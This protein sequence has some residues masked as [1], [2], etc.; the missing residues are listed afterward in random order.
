MDVSQM[1]RA[2][3]RALV[4]QFRPKMILLS[5]LPLLISLLL[6]GALMAWTLQ[7]VFDLIQSYLTEHQYFNNA[8]DVLATL[9]LMGFKAVIVPLF[10][11]WLLL[12]IMIMSS[13]LFVG[14][15]AMPVIAKHVGERDFPHIV[16]AADG[17][18]IVTLFRSIGYS[19][20]SFFLFVFA[21]ILTLPLIFFPPIYVFVQP[22]LWGW[23]TYRIMSFDALSNYASAEERKAL[24]LQHK[25]SLLAMGVI[26]G[27]FGGLPSVLWMSGAMITL[28]PFFAGVAIWLYLLIFIFTGLWFQYY[29]LYALHQKREASASQSELNQVI[30]RL[31]SE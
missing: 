4:A 9:G 14:M 20:A 26:A 7:Y 11:L 8:R 25:P 1:A 13:L 2:W 22:L 30:S 31:E 10:A 12:P 5:L 23:L 29:C 17:S 19:M 21:W 16:R 18:T 27:L 3:A 15:F 24:V 28:L 6:W